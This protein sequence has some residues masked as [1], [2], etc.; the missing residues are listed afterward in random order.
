MQYSFPLPSSVYDEI[1]A[2]VLDG[3]ELSSLQQMYTHKPPVKVPTAW[4]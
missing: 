4:E 1:I 3:R 2:I